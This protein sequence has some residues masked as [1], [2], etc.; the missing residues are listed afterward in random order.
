MRA[1]RGTMA[2]KA[3]VEDAGG[4]S[5]SA[6][7]PKRYIDLQLWHVAQTGTPSP[8][9]TQHYDRELGSCP[10]SQGAQDCIKH[11][12]SLRNVLEE[13]LDELHE[14]YRGRTLFPILVVDDEVKRGNLDTGSDPTQAGSGDG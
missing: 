7:L 10:M 6:A 5:Q 12:S 1:D 11:P 13:P 3:M 8:V 2:Q 14:A 4:T 9:M